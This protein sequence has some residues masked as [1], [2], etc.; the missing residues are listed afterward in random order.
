MEQKK[1]KKHGRGRVIIA[2]IAGLILVLC[3]LGILLYRDRLT[4]ESLRET[5]GRDTG[6]EE[7]EPFT[8]EAGSGQVFAVSGSRL[9]VA[10]ATGIQLLDEKGNTLVHEVFSMEK[11]TITANDDLCVFYDA[12]GDVLRA[13]DAGGTVQELEAEGEIIAARI[14]SGNYLAVITE[15]T[16]YKAVV[17]VYNSDLQKLFAWHSGSAYVLA[18][19]VSPNGKNLAAVCAAEEGGSMKLF[20][21]SSEEPVG[22]F[23]VSG[24]LF[25]DLHWMDKDGVCILSDG[26]MVFLDGKAQQEAEYSFS[27]KYLLDY[28]LGSSTAALLLGDH[29]AGNSGTLLMVDAGGRELGSRG[30]EKDVL[31]LSIGGDKLLILYGDTMELCTETLS[32]INS[33]DQIPGVKKALLR[34]DGKCLMLSAYGAEPVSLY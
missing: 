13:V 21:L 3:A 32:V 25:W 17:T 28:E 11:P 16:G 5:F 6:T 10:S 15:E 23:T 22:E 29:R 9:A 2:V 33:T 19:E 14:S 27:G 20:S 26:R 24:E 7:S 8:Y 34:K 12:G 1:S 18:A 4:P 31:S 30:I